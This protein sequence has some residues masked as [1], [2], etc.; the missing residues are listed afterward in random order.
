MLSQ[1]VGYK[2]RE[3]FVSVSLH[4]GGNAKW[5]DWQN[6]RDRVNELVKW[7]KNALNKGGM[8]FDCSSSISSYVL[9]RVVYF[10]CFGGRE[11]DERMTKGTS[12]HPSVYAPFPSRVTSQTV[13]SYQS[14]T[15]TEGSLLLMEYP[16]TDRNKW[17]ASGWMDAAPLQPDAHSL[18]QRGEIPCEGGG[19]ELN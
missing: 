1:V 17:I 9:M 15:I 14:T 7:Q 2:C 11:G 19:G 3:R 12:F 10:A 8:L 5:G 16:P 13:V 4:V 18:L 6:Q